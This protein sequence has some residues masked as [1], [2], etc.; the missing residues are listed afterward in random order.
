MGL[1]DDGT[2]VVVN[3]WGG[4]PHVLHG[5]VLAMQRWCSESGVAR[6]TVTDGTQQFVQSTEEVL[7]SLQRN[8]VR[9]VVLGATGFATAR[10]PLRGDS[11]ADPRFAYAASHGVDE[12][13]LHDGAEFSGPSAVHDAEVLDEAR[14]VMQ[15]CGDTAKTTAPLVLF[16]NLLSCR[17]VIRTRFRDATDC[18]VECRLLAPAVEY[19]ARLIPSSLSA[20]IPQISARFARRNSARFGEAVPPVTAEGEYVTLLREALSA[21]W[22]LQDTLDRF[23]EFAMQRGAH[24]AMTS[25][26]SLSLGEYSL[27]DDDAP[28]PSCTTTF[29]C[30]S[31]EEDA[32]DRDLTSL[33]TR[34]LCKVC[35]IAPVP[36]PS[37]SQRAM[38]ITRSE[39]DVFVRVECAVNGHRYMCTG[40]VSP[41]L[42]GGGNT[43]VRVCDADADPEEVND[44]LPSLSDTLRDRVV[45]AYISATR[46]VV[47]AAPIPVLPQRTRPTLPP[48]T[49]P[50]LPVSAY[51]EGTPP[52]FP[53]GDA[54]SSDVIPSRPNTTPPQRTGGPATQ[55]VRRLGAKNIRAK[56][57][58]LNTMHR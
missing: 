15:S 12:C 25:T 56:E 23:L 36:L 41:L 47:N 45:D 52:S 1:R 53:G 27:R 32:G 28:V 38:C 6:M 55:S 33:L 42:A 11:I 18:E 39:R 9:T 35:R 54:P 29:W 48:E 26:R 46:G 19:D 40:I 20:T 16:L 30:S 2:T 31:C 24:V 44:V 10:R 58:R 8:G 5:N 13:S 21:L 34:F 37:P 14:R 49:V 7:R 22:G 51:K 50:P 3:H 43:V 4:V 57:T 17:D